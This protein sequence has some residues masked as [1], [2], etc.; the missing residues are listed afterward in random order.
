VEAK[1]GW[2]LLVGGAL[3]AVGSF[4]PWISASTFLGTLSRSG[5]DGGG[6][7]V[8]TLAAGAILALFGGLVLSGRPV[9][10]VTRALLWIVVAFL[11]LIWILD[12]SDIRDRVDLVS[13]E[14]AQGS[15]GSGMWVMAVGA[16][17]S[18]VGI[19]NLPATKR[20]G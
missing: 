15:I 5:L 20:A 7:G 8:F 17:T 1:A 18:V 12:F 13:S 19:A 3:V 4:L 14:F 2:W 16:I 11:T 9:T 10:R 6:D